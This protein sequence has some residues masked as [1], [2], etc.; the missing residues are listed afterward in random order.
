MTN[1]I[2]L[3]RAYFIGAEAG[4]VCV[5]PNYE[6]IKQKRNA[7][8]NGTD[9]YLGD[10]VD[11]IKEVA[12][13]QPNRQLRRDDPLFNPGVREEIFYSSTFFRRR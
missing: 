9:G 8:T 6:D 12:K 5:P 4:I 2:S 3:P 1:P 11:P 7:G 13:T 10:V